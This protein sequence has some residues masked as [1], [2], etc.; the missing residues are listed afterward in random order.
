M[1]I[2]SIP[3]FPSGMS[4]C[5]GVTHNPTTAIT[6]NPQQSPSKS[7]KRYCMD[8]SGAKM[9]GLI[10]QNKQNEPESIFFFL[11]SWRLFTRCCV[12]CCICLSLCFMIMLKFRWWWK[13]GLNS[14]EWNDK[15]RINSE[16]EN[17]SDI[18]SSK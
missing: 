1:E 12:L 17:Q 10:K 2:W 4:G 13:V 14:Q 7:H 8:A 15:I 3:L 18:S 6:T 11:S 5:R 16:D 9:A